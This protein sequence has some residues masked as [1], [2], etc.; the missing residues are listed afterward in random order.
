MKNDEMHP[1]PPVMNEPPAVTLR[2]AS[3]VL[4]NIV[5]QDDPPTGPPT[6]PPTDP[7]N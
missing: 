6:D 7:P 4:D 2:T 1:V 3:A 5:A